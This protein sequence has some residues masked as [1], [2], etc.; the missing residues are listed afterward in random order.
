[1]RSKLLEFCLEKLVFMICYRFLVEYQDIRYVVIVDLSNHQHNCR[2]RRDLDSTHLFFQVFQNLRP[3]P[4][5]QIEL[6]QQVFYFR[7]LF[8]NRSPVLII[9]FV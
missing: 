7:Y 2:Q 1:M 9:I 8:G 6:L 3:V 5:D 4:L